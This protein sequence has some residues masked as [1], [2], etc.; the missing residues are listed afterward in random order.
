MGAQADYPGDEFL[1]KCADGFAKKVFSLV[2]GCLGPV[3][4]CYAG[5]RTKYGVYARWSHCC[6]CWN[7]ASA[8]CWI[9]NINAE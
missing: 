4:L 3:W 2:W 1:S 8:L 7:W 6:R 9:T 5:R